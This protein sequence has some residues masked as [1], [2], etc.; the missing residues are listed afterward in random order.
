MAQQLEKIFLGNTPSEQRKFLVAA[1]THL[2]D[3]Y[4]KVVI[5]CCGQF[6]L[7]KCAIEAGYKP[8]DITASEISL[9]SCV[10]GYVY[11]GIPLS[12]LNF[13]VLEPHKE[14]YESYK[15]DIDRAAFLLWL[16]KTQQLRTDLMYERVVYDNLVEDKERHLEGFRKQLEKNASLYKGITFRI[17]DLR[18]E[19]KE[20]W[21]DDTIVIVNPPAFRGGYEKMFNF[22]K[23]LSFDPNID[24]FDLGK[25]YA[26]L[27]EQSKQKAH[28]T[29]W[30]KYKE[31]DGFNPHEVVY[32]REYFVDR[33]DFWL[34]TKPEILNDFRFKGAVT[35]KTE[36]ELKKYRN[37]PMWG[38]DDVLKPDTKVEFRSVPSEV[39]LYYRDLW[40]HKLGNTKAEHYYIILLDGKVFATVGFHTSELFRLKSTRVFE[41]YGFNA[42]SRVHPRINRLMMMLITCSEMGGVLRRDSSNVNRVYELK[43]LR[44]TCLSK[45]RKVK[46]NNGILKIEKR[47]KMPDGVYKIMYDTDF[48]NRTFAQC[49]IDYLNEE[50]GV[51]SDDHGDD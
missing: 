31:V 27:Y 45:Y 40:A 13:E 18:D 42:P 8:E 1:L 25:E 46:L 51:T 20:E 34:L 6:T 49:V 29:F 4:Q 38:L 5:P 30:Y 3:R 26:T 17:R 12:T 44:T 23:V 41:N 10:L 28:P 19:L 15:N 9:F 22:S 14:E 48:H 50:Q 2:H 21:S 24:E 7:A 32:G 35:F 39:A 33:Y 43:G 47:E 11:G 37:V 16:M 36:H